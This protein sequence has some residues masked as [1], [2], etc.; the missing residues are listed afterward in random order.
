MSK[1]LLEFYHSTP[2][3]IRFNDLDKLGHVNNSVY[4]QFL[5]LGKISYFDHVLQENMDWKA[6]GLIIASI[7]INFLKPI[8]LNDSIG[9]RNK[10][11]RIG[12]KS[13]ELQQEVFCSTSGEVFA[14]SS[15]V[16][17]GVNGTTNETI[18]IPLRWRQRIARFEKDLQLEVK[19][20]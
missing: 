5:D 2:V 3:Q 15:S 11:T 17:V 7:T 18:P 16:M 13:L 8:K 12:N 10:T 20:D 6:E 19:V 9:V 4:Q 1:K 14:S